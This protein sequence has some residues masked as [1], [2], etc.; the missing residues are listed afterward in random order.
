M[1]R[2]LFLKSELNYV[3]KVNNNTVYKYSPRLSDYRT[4]LTN[5]L[6]NFS[7]AEMAYLHYVQT[8]SSLEKTLCSKLLESPK[9]EYFFYSVSLITV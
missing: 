4:H 8:I 2:E 1:F 6:R 9:K 7:N 5:A 3:R